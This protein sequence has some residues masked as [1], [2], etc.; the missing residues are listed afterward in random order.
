[1]AIDPPKPSTCKEPSDS[2]HD[3]K[4]DDEDPDDDRFNA[5][6]AFGRLWVPA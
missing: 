5:A 1:M 2:D 3:E 6:A 4:P